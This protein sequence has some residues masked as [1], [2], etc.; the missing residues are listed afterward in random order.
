MPSAS[1]F[2]VRLT[3]SSSHHFPMCEEV[4]ANKTSIKLTDKTNYKANR[5]L[6]CHQS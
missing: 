2:E 3:M 1:L 4:P 5:T 6:M